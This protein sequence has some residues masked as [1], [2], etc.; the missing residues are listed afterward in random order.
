[1]LCSKKHIFIYIKLISCWHIMAMAT[2]WFPA[3][4]FYT[5]HHGVHKNIYDLIEFHWNTC[6]Q[7]LYI[8]A[9]FIVLSIDGSFLICWTFLSPI[10]KHTKVLSCTIP[11]I[12]VQYIVMILLVFGV[13]C[14]WQYDKCKIYSCH[15]KIYS[16]HE[17]ICWR[18]L[19][20]Q[21]M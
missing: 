14:F 18:S 2:T 13:L 15:S 20:F 9:I 4:F 19:N 5:C 6:S 12:W 7:L 16:Q 10:Q 3:L 8:N 17:N 21:L 11:Y 1:M